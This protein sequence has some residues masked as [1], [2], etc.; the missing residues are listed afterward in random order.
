M[1][2]TKWKRWRNYL[3]RICCVRGQMRSQHNKLPAAHVSVKRCQLE[4]KQKFGG[5]VYQNRHCEQFLGLRCKIVF[6]R[7]VMV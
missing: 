1:C 6:V 5:K 7:G 3:V 4:P 2:H